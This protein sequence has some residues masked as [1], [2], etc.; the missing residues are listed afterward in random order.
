MEALIDLLIR[1]W[2][3]EVAFER[4]LRMQ[5]KLLEQQEGRKA[6]GLEWIGM[7]HELRRTIKETVAEIT[8][9]SR[10]MED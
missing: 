8:E 7:R 9:R 10:E 4:A 5:I 2:Q 1:I 3:A 6:T